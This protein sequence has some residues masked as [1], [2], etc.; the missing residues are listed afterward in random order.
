MCRLTEMVLRP[1]DPKNTIYNL[2]YNLGTLDRNTI[3]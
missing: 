2:V 1:L 3:G